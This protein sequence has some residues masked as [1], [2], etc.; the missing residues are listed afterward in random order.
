MLK[1]IAINI[2][3]LIATSAS[4]FAGAKFIEY[5]WKENELDVVKAEQLKREKK[6]KDRHAQEL[7]E[8][9]EKVQD[10]Q[11]RLSIFEMDENA[12]LKEF[13][14]QEA[15]KLQKH[16]Q[17]LIQK[18]LEAST[19]KIN[20]YLSSLSER[21]LAAEL[22]ITDMEA[23]LNDIENA[24]K[25]QKDL[26]QLAAKVVADDVDA[27]GRNYC[28]MDALKKEFTNL[29]PL[30]RQY[31]TQKSSQFTLFK[32][33]M[34]SLLSRAMF[35][36]SPAGKDDVIYHIQSALDSGQ[37]IL[38]LRLYQSLQGWPRLIL[39][40]WADRSYT[41]LECIQEIQSS[42]YLNKL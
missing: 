16:A 8:K 12:R 39:R 3:E 6:L 32:Y 15:E 40:D 31:S 29:V 22:I 17:S 23:D 7:S 1:T 30:L 27:L 20:S 4:T 28:S 2:F 41:R 38:A 36:D 42:L 10:L 26:E 25:G 14:C 19:A 13:K 11:A 37:L 34:S 24:K 18:H 21:L 9:E 35:T 33:L 5:R